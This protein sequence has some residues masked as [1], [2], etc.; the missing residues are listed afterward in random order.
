VLDS[1]RRC[2]EITRLTHAELKKLAELLG[3]DDERG[4][5]NWRFALLQH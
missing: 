4:H 5:G 1:N 3:A 2:I